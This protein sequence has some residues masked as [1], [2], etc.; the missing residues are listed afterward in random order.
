MKSSQATLDSFGLLAATLFTMK[1]FYGISES[2]GHLM[3]PYIIWISYATALSYWT[4]K[5]NKKLL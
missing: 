3:M 4:W 1:S 5:I 2:A